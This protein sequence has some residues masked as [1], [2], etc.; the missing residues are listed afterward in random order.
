M[1]TFNLFIL[2]S[3]TI[4]FLINAGYAKAISDVGKLYM[5]FVRHPVKYPDETNSEY[6][7]FI[8]GVIEEIHNIIIDN[9]EAYSN[10]SEIDRL[11]K[12]YDQR[13]DS[14]KFLKDYGN[15]GTVY[16]IFG[17]EDVTCLYAFLYPDLT[18][19]IKSLQ[20][21]SQI[22]L[23]TTYSPDDDNGEDYEDFEP[24]EGSFYSVYV[25]NPYGRDE[26][27]QEYK[28]YLDRILN[29]IH[30]VIENNMDTYKN[31]SKLDEIQKNFDENKG[32]TLKN[33]GKYGT[34]YPVVTLNETIIIEAYL[35]PNIIEKIKTIESVKSV[36]VNTEAEL[37][38]PSVEPSVEPTEEQNDCKANLIGYSCCSDSNT[39]VVYH[40]DDGD[41]GIEN[42][43]WCGITSISSS[44]SVTE[45]DKCFSEFLGY[46]CCSSCTDVVFTDE[47]G[48]WGIE[49]GN[50]CGIRNSC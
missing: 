29:Q 2:L 17:N 10:S 4:T 36:G 13:K 6:K 47:D 22:N 38:Q 31:P 3:I 50:W 1:K 16:R 5:V 9:K 48:K 25:A 32:K 20:Y 39:T 14:G 23:P 7:E 33:Y 21:I 45:D 34:V 41:W 37:A 18:E 46:S 49:D 15:Y 40:D 24:A 26:S 19:E 30:F 8:N 11:Q 43:E 42:N 12:E 44:T 27:S 28:D 35:N